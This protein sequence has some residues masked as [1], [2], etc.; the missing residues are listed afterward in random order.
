M[1]RP[2]MTTA[3]KNALATAH[4]FPVLLVELHFNSA[5][6]YVWTGYNNIT[7]N[8]HT[9]LGV[10]NLGGVAEVVDTLE[11]SMNG[12]TLTLTGIP[13]TDTLGAA[14][15][16]VS[17]V[18]N[19]CKQ[20]NPVV[21]YFG[22]F[23]NSGLGLIA[24]PVV[25]FL[26]RMDKIQINEGAESVVVQMNVEPRRIDINRDRDRRYTDQDQRLTYPTDSGFKQVTDLAAWNGTQGIGGAGAVPNIPTKITGGG[27]YTNIGGP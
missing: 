20:S 22:L 11:V 7:W 6:S 2:G 27:M 23:D 4:V 25:A 8:G 1:P 16:P 12:T 15:D 24:D 3:M 19:Q 14:V 17:Q 9:W 10:G 13:Y 21:I 5:T 26:G 18:L